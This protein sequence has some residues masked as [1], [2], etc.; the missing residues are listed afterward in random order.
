M[1]IFQTTEPKINWK[2]Y[3]QLK[4][5]PS[6]FYLKIHLK[7]GFLKSK[8]HF[9][10][11]ESNWMPWKICQKLFYSCRWAM[12]SFGFSNYCF[13]F[14]HSWKCSFLWC[15]FRVDSI[16]EIAFFN[17][18]FKFFFKEVGFKKNNYS[19]QV[20]HLRPQLWHFSAQRAPKSENFPLCF[21]LWSVSSFTK[22]SYLKI[23]ASWLIENMY[24]YRYCVF[25][26]K[27]CL[28]H[29]KPNKTLAFV[30]QFVT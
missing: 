17:K 7:R 16:A 24:F 3:E 9:M 27:I 22:S 5:T 4:L 11:D 26:T 14:F 13:Y 15:T 8:E 2:L 28:Q 29:V 6:I 18:K 30:F 1:G 25:F 20:P 21:F 10:K 23:A 12:I 19:P